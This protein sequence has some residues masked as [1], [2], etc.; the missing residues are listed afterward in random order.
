MKN[1]KI[2]K[3]SL[4]NKNKKKLL[5]KSINHQFH[6]QRKRFLKTVLKVQQTLNSA[7]EKRKK[8]VKKLKEDKINVMTPGAFYTRPVITK[9]IS[10]LLVAELTVLWKMRH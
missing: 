9:I 1:V 3:Q 8:V 5:V 2:V 7:Q 10:G 6:K 4:N